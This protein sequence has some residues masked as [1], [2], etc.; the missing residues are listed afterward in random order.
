PGGMLDIRGG[1]AEHIIATGRYGF[2]LGRGAALRVYGRYRDRAPSRLS[3]DGA[4]EDDWEQGQGGFR[5]DLDPSPRDHITLQG[6]AYTGS[7]GQ[8][9]NFAQPTPPF[10]GM[11]FD[12]LDVSGANILGRWT[13]RF[14]G[15]DE[16]QLQA[17]F[18]RAVRT[19]PS[20]FGRIAVNI[21]DL[22]LQHHIRLSSRHDLLWGFGYRLNADT[23][24]GTFATTLVPP[25]RTTHLITAFAQD[26]VA[27]FPGRL[28]AT[29]GAKLER[30]DFS[31][32]ELQ[33]NLR[34]LWTPGRRHAIWS[35]ISR[36]VR[37]PSRLD[38]DVRFV[39]QVLPGTP[40]TQV[41]FDGNEDFDSEEMVS[42][43]AGWRSEPYRSISLDLSLYYSWYDRLRTIAPLP[44]TVDGGFAVQPFEVRNDLEGHAYGG[45]LAAS[46]RPAR[47]LVFRGSYTL[48][49][50]DLNL[51]GTAPPGSTPNVNP[52]FNPGHQASLRSSLTLPPG[53]DVDL[54]L[55]YVG[56]LPT[57]PISEY[58]Q[59]DA[60]VGWAARPDISLAVVG[61]D[62]FARR[63]A[64]FASVPQRE[65]QRRAEVQFE[66]RF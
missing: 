53:I 34:L 63:H 21:F 43:E 57:P 38:A 45:T 6:D 24:S 61:R 52:G 18:D 40:P 50:M 9:V 49:E 30:N 10:A 4:G 25:G 31:G 22:D 3:G 56:T 41:R 64:E 62:L 39:G 1:S 17:Y 15:D 28:S 2:D 7:G 8:V 65:I 27:I 13:H 32:A 60:R 36:A 12:E 47:D 16:L 29:V 58:L 35:A 44:P 19:V 37:I 42:W 46:W 55:R 14:L 66:W 11:A 26:E 48:L 5:A 54:M 23:I 33:P 51:A 59:A 20:S